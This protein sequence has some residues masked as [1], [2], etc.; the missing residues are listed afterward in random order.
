MRGFSFVGALLLGALLP[1]VAGAQQVAPGEPAEPPV[2]APAPLDGR[3]R[4]LSAQ[5]ARYGRHWAGFGPHGLAAD[6]PLDRVG[7]L[8]RTHRPLEEP[9]RAQLEHLGVEFL[10]R[11]AGDPVRVGEVYAV[12]VLLDAAERV[13]AHPA[14]AR[15]SC[16][17]SP[18]FLRPLDTVRADQ[19]VGRIQGRPADAPTGAG[20]LVADIDSPVDVLHPHLFHA[21]GGAYA[22]IDVDGDGWLTPGVDGVDLDGDGLL[23]EAERLQTLTGVRFNL[24]DFQ[25]FV[26]LDEPFSPRR[27][28]LYLDLNGDGER[29][30]GRSGGFDERTPAYGEPIF[31][32]EDLDGDG[33]I[34]FGEL[35]YRLDSSK[36]R[37]ALVDGTRY[38]RGNGLGNGLID[39]ARALEEHD[40]SHGTGVASIVLGGQWPFHDTVGLAPEAELY[41]YAQVS[42]NPGFD[43]PFP[44]EA[45]DDALQK[46]AR[47]ILHEWTDPTASIQDGGG[48][49]EAAM[50]A[51]RA[52]GLI[53]VNPLGNLNAAGKH[54]EAQVGAEGTFT[55]AF[56]VGAGYQYG[57]SLM[58]YTVIYGMV[59]W[60]G[61]GTPQL[62]LV[63]PDG[64][65]Y[66]VEATGE[67]VRLGA[68]GD[69]GAAVPMQS[70]KGTH[71]LMFYVFRARFE[72]TTGV[73]Q[74]TWQVDLEGLPPQ[75]SIYGRITDYW[76][77]WGPGVGWA[78]PTVDRGTLVYPSTA[79]SA[80]GVAA[81]GGVN[82]LIAYDGTLKGQLRNYSGRGPRMLDDARAVDVAAPDDPYA[83]FARQSAYLEAGYGAHWFSTFGGTSGAAPHVAA[84]LAMLSEQRPEA[85]ADELEQ[86]LIDASRTDQLSAYAEDL[87]NIHWG[88]GKLDVW[89]LFNGA[90]ARPGG[91]APQAALKIYR[92]GDQVIFD[93]S[94]STDAD[95]DALSWRFDM[96]GQGAW[97]GPF[98]GQP[99][100]SVP[101]EQLPELA[102][103]RVQV[104]DDTGLWAGLAVPYARE[105]LP[106]APEP[107]PDQGVA[108]PVGDG[109]LAD[110]EGE[111]GEGH[112][113][114]QPSG[115]LD[116][117]GA[118]VQIVGG[119]STSGG[120][121]QSELPG[122]GLGLFAVLLAGVWRRR[123]A[124]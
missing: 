6:L 25:G 62:T 21:D 76:S 93:A 92:R 46:G 3:F 108:P 111:P 40:T 72:D 123:R 41:S 99:L 109:G 69:Y 51:A 86:R 107:Q 42:E 116:D 115:D 124:G 81:F 52:Q 95:G 66:E 1:A 65:R 84:A 63:K 80:L 17:W 102:V 29:N 105:A 78:Q 54:F 55:A 28:W 4:L 33:R 113:D 67:S 85:S 31:V 58:P 98:N 64:Q 88:H 45:I 15:L 8:L 35:L 106:E 110:A 23:S 56:N 61:E 19:G 59:M 11:E 26:G 90:T 36:V 44:V 89:Q 53:Q 121:A 32:A 73:A 13:N 71:A 16:A 70:A 119:R 79:D 94:E 97:D 120:C 114:A 30:T 12:R 96:D 112:A 27:D 57:E 50:D 37:G 43:R 48:E 104:A 68:G 77:S 9:Q 2:A 10:R 60:P 49:V 24:Y 122:S 38:T 18:Q 75:V 100:R 5:I 7:A 74:G 117:G 91:E 20:V 14:V 87:P 47:M 103:A 82:H 22:W 34:G 39:M 101:A 83:A 118:P